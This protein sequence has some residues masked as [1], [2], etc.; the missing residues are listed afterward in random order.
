MRTPFETHNQNLTSE[1]NFEAGSAL[2]AENFNQLIQEIKDVYYAFCG[3]TY[4]TTTLGYI[5]NLNSS[6]F[7][8]SP[9]WGVSTKGKGGV[10]W[11]NVDEFNID[12]WI[13]TNLQMDFT[14]RTAD[15]P[16]TTVSTTSLSFLLPFYPFKVF[17]SSENT[18]NVHTIGNVKYCSNTT[19]TIGSI[20][21]K[22][23][24]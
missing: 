12:R 6:N 24:D 17:A 15:S 19:N 5:P 2:K 11:C 13:A 7:L 18:A 4:Y 3:M 22:E 23:F 10:V 20:C 16:T 1:G 8:I 21:Y 14:K 9:F